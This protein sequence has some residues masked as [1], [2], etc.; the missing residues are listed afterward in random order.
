MEEFAILYS[1]PLLPLS[2]LTLVGL[3]LGHG[4]LKAAQD[5]SRSSPFFFS[6]RSP[7]DAK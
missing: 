5:G 3:S 4:D 1:L 6:R 7:G 2:F